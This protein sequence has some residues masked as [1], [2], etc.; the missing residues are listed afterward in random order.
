M[1]VGSEVLTKSVLRA[2]PSYAM[3]ACKLLDSF[4]D[5][6]WELMSNF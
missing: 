5:D 2:I 6:I 3:G 1:I 4:Y